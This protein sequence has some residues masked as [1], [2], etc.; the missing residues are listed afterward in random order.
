MNYQ[1]FFQYRLQTQRTN[2]VTIYD[3][4]F[5]SMLI[6]IISRQNAHAFKRLGSSTPLHIMQDTGVLVAILKNKCPH[7]R[8]LKE[9]NQFA[10]LNLFS[11]SGNFEN[12]Q[13]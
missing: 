13:H 9:L 2:H 6:L 10:V 1:P 12:R 4:Y 5:E 11:H 3:E 8:H 7:T